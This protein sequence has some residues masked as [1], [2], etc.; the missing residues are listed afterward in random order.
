M[1]NGLGASRINDR[2]EGRGGM[3]WDEVCG[4]CGG[5]RW[6]KSRSN[7][8]VC[9]ICHPDVLDALEQ[10]ARRRPGLVEQVKR[11]RLQEPAQ[12]CVRQMQGLC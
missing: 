7:Y 11:W 9:A 5:R 10:L 2:R 3:G 1:R 8:Q 12:S 4:V 6:W